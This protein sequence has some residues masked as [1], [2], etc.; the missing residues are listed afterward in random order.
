MSPPSLNG[1]PEILVTHR[2]FPE[3]A[4]LLR[5][6]GR[7]V[8]PARA[9]AL[10]PAVRRRHARTAAALLAFMPDHV[11]ER[12][13]A[14][15]PN[16][17]IVAG[18]LKGYDNVDAAACARRGVWLT[19]VPDLLTA[20]AAELTIGLM[21]ALGRSVRAGDRL[22]RTGRYDGWRPRLYGRGLAGETV[23]LVG[24][25]AIGAGV[26]SRLGAFG[27]TLL[28]AD[29]VALSRAAEQRLRLTRL[30]LDRLLARAGY[31]V[32]AAPLTRQTHHL[33]D[34]R[35]IARMR[36]GALLINPSRGSLVDEAAV[37]AALATGR[38]GGYAADAFEMEDLR[39]DDRPRAIVR[40]L[41]AHPTTLFTPHLGSAVVA[42]RRAIER[43]AAENILDCFAGRPP[44]DAVAGPGVPVATLRRGG[45]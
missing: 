20:P 32:L 8:V 40:A 44:R 4:A 16:L 10:S 19:I 27:A 5:R 24:M 30:P 9:A 13:L 21:I 31:V 25:G 6:S 35:R 1:R 33:L 26:A 14:G 18:A 3:T 2:V 12:F 22:M 29:P 7:V 23:G 39:R 15:A 11:D 34:A 41:R 37:A 36:R 42:A 45:P 38:L 28:Y 43:R 17:R